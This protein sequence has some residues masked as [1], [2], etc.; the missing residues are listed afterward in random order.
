[1]QEDNGFTLIELLVVVLIIGVLAAIAIPQFSG[2]R[3]KAFDAS[4]RSDLRNM[5]TAMESYFSERYAYTG[6]TVTAGGTAD[7]DGDGN[8]ELQASSGV[9]LQSTAYTDGFQA[10]SVHR[11]STS[12][13]CVDSSASSA[14]GSVGVIVQA[15]SC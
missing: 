2:T 11:S 6:A 14:T 1:M 13:W 8:P 10:T 7:L 3:E 4:S 9:S 15:A 5:M 12:T